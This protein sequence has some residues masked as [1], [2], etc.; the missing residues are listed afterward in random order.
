MKTIAECS[1]IGC[2]FAVLFVLLFCMVVPTY[3]E[4]Q[5]HAELCKTVIRQMIE[6]MQN[7]RLTPTEKMIVVVPAL[8]VEPSPDSIYGK[9]AAFFNNKI[10]D[11]IVKR[12][13]VFIIVVEPP[14][15]LELNNVEGYTIRQIKK[16]D[17]FVDEKVD[18][19][20]SRPNKQQIA[21]ESLELEYFA[22]HP[23][24]IIFFQEF[25]AI[26]HTKY[27]VKI[28][29]DPGLSLSGYSMNVFVEKISG[30]WRVG[31]VKVTSYG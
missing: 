30:Q 4:K 13:I 18:W 28:S 12:K 1:L 9:R 20:Q 22:N 21:Y 24:S 7:P 5:L 27:L 19:I 2:F 31:K 17:A 10:Q 26:S 16:V 25:K 3:Q 8:V 11:L 15:Q 29:V 6:T 14:L 23:Y